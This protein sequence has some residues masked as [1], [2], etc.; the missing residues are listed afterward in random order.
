MQRCE[1]ELRN[2]LVDRRKELL[3]TPPERVTG[4]ELL[5]AHSALVDEVLRGVYD[6]S[7]RHALDTQAEHFDPDRTQLAII[8]TGGY[9]RCELNPFSDIDIAF[10]PSEEDNLFLD[11]ATKEAFRLVVELFL[12][13]TDLQVGYAYRPLGD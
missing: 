4:S 12:D 6:L 2:F 10:V 9:G 7:S 1:A 8:A 11:A 5:A 3:A 13:S